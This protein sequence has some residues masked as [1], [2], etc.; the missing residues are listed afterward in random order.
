MKNSIVYWY[1]FTAYT[2][3]QYRSIGLMCPYTS[4]YRARAPRSAIWA[5]RIS[6]FNQLTSCNNVE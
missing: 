3:Y 6:I 5:P 4:H 1:V 2:I